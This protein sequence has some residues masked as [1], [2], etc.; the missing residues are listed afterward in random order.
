MK[1][2]VSEVFVW[3]Q[4]DGQAEVNREELT[5]NSIRLPGKWLWKHWQA[6]GGKHWHCP[7][8]RHEEEFSIRKFM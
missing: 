5:Q 1:K 7:N 2:I 4:Q 3:Y 8:A 6:F